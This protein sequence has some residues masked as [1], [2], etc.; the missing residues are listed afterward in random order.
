MSGVAQRRPA[1]VEAIGENLRDVPWAEREVLLDDVTLHLGDAG[2]AGRDIALWTERFGSPADYARQL[3]SD[4]G[5]PSD[6]AGL[7]R[8]RRFR[9]R[10][11]RLRVQLLCGFAV[12][13]VGVLVA[14]VLWAHRV[15]P[16][17]FGDVTA[18]PGAEELEA[19]GARDY[20]WRWTRGRHFAIG[21]WLRND[22]AVPV[23]VTALDLGQTHVPW[24][25]W[26]VQLATREQELRFRATR[27][28]SPFTLA[29]GERRLIWFS[30]DFNR[31]PTDYE[32]GTATGISDIAATFKVLGITRRERLPLRFTYSVKLDHDCS[33]RVRRPGPAR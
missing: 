7:R 20:R 4:L 6:P 5:L 30:G 9:F 26:Q 32:P 15:E 16:L 27:R 28:F 21:T 18:A 1:Y 11:A 31:C 23:R 2:L 29:P 14:A 12:V 10:H 33:H 22:A 13:V 17:D 25:N 24:D 3:R 19:G 8:A